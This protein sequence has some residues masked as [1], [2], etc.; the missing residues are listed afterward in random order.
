M[1]I[2]LKNLL[3]NTGIF[4]V[5][6]ML[7]KI[8]MFVM[9]PVYTYY[10]TT[11]EYGIVDTVITTSNLLL[12]IATVGIYEAVLRFGIKK[13]TSQSKVLSNALFM[14]AISVGLLTALYPVVCINA[15][16]R[17]YY[18]PFCLI[19]ILDEL[20]NVFNAFSKSIGRVAV[21]AK[22]S[23]YRTI[24][25][26]LLSI[27]FI[28]V[29]HQKTYGYLYAL[30][31][32]EFVAILVFIIHEK[33]YKYICF[34]V[35]FELLKKML[36]YSCPL[37]INGVMWWI[38]QS[39][40]KYEL[41][42]FLGIASTGIYSVANKVPSIITMLHSTFF[43]AWQ[44]SAIEEYGSEEVSEY[45][46]SIF[47]RYMEVAFLFAIGSIALVKPI[48]GFV[49]ETS[50][51]D[52]WKYSL[53]LILASLFSSFSS[54]FGT[55]YSAAEKT[56]GALVTSLI[57]A[58]TNIIMNFILISGYGIQGAS[59]AT[60]FSYFIMWVI[61]C[62]DTRKYVRIKINVPEFLI[63][64][65]ACFIMITMLLLEKN[66]IVVLC[67]AVVI[68]VYNVIYVYKGVKNENR[69]NNNTFPV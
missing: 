7:T 19:L 30:V 58:A 2:K 3:K 46:S 55:T 10:L 33:F 29:L 68:S 61:R 69:N 27:I 51:K 44:I 38:M 63:N 6:N 53:F 13:E 62:Y 22:I 18:L 12:P 39:A 20:L 48:L 16:I 49:L 42:Y 25:Y 40:D 45:Y 26:V 5:A 17:S 28:I 1:N 64:I 35:D 52:A 8:I 31:F 57:G 43:Q 32:S 41:I 23:V 11:E 50:Y 60:F 34:P 14:V 56:K 21:S 67:I 47:N 66:Y 24:L 65:F 59:F 54:F 36:V 37:M 4:A 9:V 15:D